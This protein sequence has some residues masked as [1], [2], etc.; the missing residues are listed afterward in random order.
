MAPLID[1]YET[2]T[3]DL[4]FAYLWRRIESF[5]GGKRA[6]EAGPSNS[7]KKVRTIARLR[8]LPARI[9]LLQAM[10]SASD[11]DGASVDFCR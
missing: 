1:F 2:G 8:P 5:V 6:N 7:V 11:H 4:D 9:V 10:E 3:V